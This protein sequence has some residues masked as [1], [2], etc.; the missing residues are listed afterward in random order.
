[1][2]TLPTTMNKQHP[3]RP[4][5]GF[6][7]IELIVVL[8]LLATIAAL[9]APRLTGS[10]RLQSVKREAGRMA[11]LTVYAQR[12]ALSRAVPM[13]VWILPDDGIYGVAPVGS[14][15]ILVGDEREFKVAEGIR[16]KVENTPTTAE[17]IEMVR[18]LPDA[19]LAEGY[20]QTVN[21]YDDHG[22]TRVLQCVDGAEFQVLR[23]S[24]L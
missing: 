1:M 20:L 9:A 6:T 12:Q 21:L 7:L 8:G 2:T 11:G 5:A 4:Q 16:I 14:F 15:A 24:M 13:V 17:R 23:E 10:S 3:R 22:N 19:T 18:F